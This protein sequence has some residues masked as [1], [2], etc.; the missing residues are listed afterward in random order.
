MGGGRSF[1]APLVVAVP[2]SRR[3]RLPLLVRLRCLIS[4]S[5][6]A[7][8]SFARH[9]GPR[10]VLVSGFRVWPRRAF[11][12]FEVGVGFCRSV[13]TAATYRLALGRAPRFGRRSRNL[14]GQREVRAARSLRPIG[15]RA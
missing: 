8:V 2:R 5:R 14:A 13:C 7:A 15:A 4:P 9:A 6:V 1:A 11:L 10:L 3:F 12:P